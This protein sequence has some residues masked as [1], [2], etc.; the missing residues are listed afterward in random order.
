MPKDFDFDRDVLL[1]LEGNIGKTSCEFQVFEMEQDTDVA[2]HIIARALPTN[3][4]DALSMLEVAKCH[5]CNIAVLIASAHHILKIDTDEDKEMFMSSV[6]KT[7]GDMTE[8]DIVDEA[9]DT[10]K[11]TVHPIS[12]TKH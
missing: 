4:K 6:M 8:A 3:G 5:V 2:V 12:G 10:P 9:P 7:L 11:A 1:P